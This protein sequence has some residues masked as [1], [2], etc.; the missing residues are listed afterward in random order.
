MKRARS[1]ADMGESSSS[2]TAE[3]NNS[4]KNE[5]VHPEHPKVAVEIPRS[6]LIAHYDKAP[7]QH[8]QS[9]GKTTSSEKKRGR[10]STGTTK[11]KA[12]VSESYTGPEKREQATPKEGLNDGPR[13]WSKYP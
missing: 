7:E 5:A 1:D 10:S 13:I 9:K 6:A 3:K 4:G 8:S 11:R 2:L 12:H